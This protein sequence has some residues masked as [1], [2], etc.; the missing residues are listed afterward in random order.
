MPLTGRIVP[1]AIRFEG[2]ILVDRRGR[3]FVNE[4]APQD[5]TEAIRKAGGLRLVGRRPHGGGRRR[6]MRSLIMHEGVITG[7]D[8]MDLAQRINCR[9]RTCARP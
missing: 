2:A 6:Q 7:R 1:E 8:E 3:R 4:W 9:P 5:I